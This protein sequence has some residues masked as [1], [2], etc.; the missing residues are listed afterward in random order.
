MF[1]YS[2]EAIRRRLALERSNGIRDTEVQLAVL[3][4]ATVLLV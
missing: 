2:R 1:F 4:F 3:A